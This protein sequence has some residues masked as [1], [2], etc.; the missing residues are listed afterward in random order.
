MCL[1]YVYLWFFMILVNSLQVADW[2]LVE[3]EGCLEAGSHL[4][5][6]LVTWGIVLL[7]GEFLIFSLISRKG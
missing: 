5:K 6:V 4:I 1:S 3:L 2:M 7:E